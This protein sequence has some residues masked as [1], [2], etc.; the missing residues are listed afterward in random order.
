VNHTD[1]FISPN[2][3]SIGGLGGD[4]SGKSTLQKKVWKQT[5]KTGG[6]HFSP[7]VSKQ[8]AAARSPAPASRAGLDEDVGFRVVRALLRHVHI[9]DPAVRGGEIVFQRVSPS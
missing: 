3:S 2:N 9:R 5:G 7:A 4:F 8:I 1:N 6:D